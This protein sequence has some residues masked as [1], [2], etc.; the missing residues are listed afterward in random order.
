[1]KNEN[2]TTTTIDILTPFHE[3][4]RVIFPYVKTV[5]FTTV[6]ANFPKLYKEGERG[7]A[8]AMY[9]IAVPLT[10]GVLKR[11]IDPNK[12]RDIKEGK[13]G[14]KGYNPAIA[15][16]QKRLYMEL[17]AID[18]LE[19]DAINSQTTIFTKKGKYKTVDSAYYDATKKHLDIS[20][21]SKCLDI[22][23]EMC[24]FLTDYIKTN[25]KLPD[26]DIVEEID[27]EF[28]R[29]YRNTH[30]IAIVHKTVKQ[31][32]SQG[33]AK[34][35]RDV[36]RGESAVVAWDNGMIYFDSYEEER[37]E[38]AVGAWEQIYSLSEMELI[39]NIIDVMD[40]VPEEAIT[41]DYIR[42]GY[43][44]L[45]ISQIMEIS[46]T[47]VYR[48]V[49]SIRCKITEIYGMSIYL[50]RRTGKDRYIQHCKDL[51]FIHAFKKLEKFK[52]DYAILTK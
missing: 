29:T 34:A 15:D 43:S 44:M 17:E 32:P 30:K 13:T 6:K 12:T 19:E 39:D 27:I 1:M 4:Y 26:F 45:H 28:K 48:R 10:N 3:H 18:S 42:S 50:D 20:A 25:N 11:L 9:S 49:I 41:L 14:T 40:L 23:N 5:D 46:H 2:I 31:T 38:W 51:E 22:V 33:M 35:G 8:A 16:L 52:T 37:A 47:T 7:R 24:I 21:S 36:V